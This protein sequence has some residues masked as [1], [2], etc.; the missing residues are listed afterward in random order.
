[1][2]RGQW[3]KRVSRR[4]CG[5]VAFRTCV[6]HLT[7]RFGKTIER[8]V[9]VWHDVGWHHD[10]RTVYN[11]VPIWWFGR[12]HGGMLLYGYVSRAQ[13]NKSVWWFGA[14]TSEC[15]YMVIWRDLARF[16]EYMYQHNILA[17]AQ[18]QVCWCVFV[19]RLI[20]LFVVT[21]KRRDC[22]ASHGVISA[23]RSHKH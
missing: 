1:M 15:A 19:S 17:H 23:R 14:G 22:S 18:V 8:H 12:G 9:W 10:C 20:Y 16:D 13:V 21:M 11:R 5:E 4:V 7:M 6:V 2:E 3:V